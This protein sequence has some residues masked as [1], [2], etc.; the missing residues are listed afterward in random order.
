M[1]QNVAI[2]QNSP[3]KGHL[4][5]SLVTVSSDLANVSKK[6]INSLDVQE[7]KKNKY[8]YIYIMNKQTIQ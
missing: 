3:W 1:S 7:N 6:E 5:D 2:D 8:I 4:N